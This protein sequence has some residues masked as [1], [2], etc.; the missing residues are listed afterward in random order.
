MNKE[1]LAMT[2]KKFIDP[3]E[4]PLFWR[5]PVLNPATNRPKTTFVAAAGCI[6]SK[7]FLLRTYTTVSYFTL[8]C[9][10]GFGAAAAA[11]FSSSKRKHI[12]TRKNMKWEQC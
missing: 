7:Y 3:E 10:L 1:R 5:R 4:K 6:N 12:S 11:T 9:G 8:F 2:F